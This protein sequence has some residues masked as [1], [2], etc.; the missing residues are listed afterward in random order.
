MTPVE[1][2]PTATSLAGHTLSGYAQL[3]LFELVITQLRPNAISPMLIIY[4]SIPL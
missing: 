2:D 3:Q 1:I 4:N